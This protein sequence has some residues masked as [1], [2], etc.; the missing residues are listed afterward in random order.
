MEFK[1]QRFAEG[2][3]TASENTAANNTPA[4]N[5]VDDMQ[6]KIDAAVTAQLAKLQAKLE[7]DF[8][9]RED[10]A[11]LSDDERAKVELENTRNE[12]QKQKAEFEREKLK[13][14]AAKV[15]SQRNLPVDFVGYL[16]G[17]D[18]EKTLANIKTFETKF[19]KAVESAVTEK[20]KGTAPQT[21]GKSIK[22][23]NDKSNFMKAI[24]D[25]QVKYI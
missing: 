18:N 19:N 22:N 4:N 24:L 3:N 6:S 10:L 2:E 21:S 7:Q 9:K 17:D 5:S 23:Q 12:L 14:E 15:L 20:L 1:L 13:Y 11:K 25:A 8:K 16:I